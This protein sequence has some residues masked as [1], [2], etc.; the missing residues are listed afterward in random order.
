MGLSDSAKRFD[1]IL[2]LLVHSLALLLQSPAG[3]GFHVFIIALLP[4][5][6]KHAILAGAFVDGSSVVRGILHVTY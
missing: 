2:R 3:G 1:Q 6:Q 5:V 4:V